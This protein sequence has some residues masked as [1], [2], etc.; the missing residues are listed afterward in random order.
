[1]DKGQIREVVSDPG[2]IRGIYNYCDRWCERCT[3]SARC[4]V[5]AAEQASPSID[6]D[7]AAFWRQ[8]H[9][10]LGVAMELLKEAAD[11]YG[12]DFDP[13]M[14]EEDEALEQAGIAGSGADQI[15]NAVRLH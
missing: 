14:S 13:L 11:E 6:M 2:L 12:L 7:N 15:N 5:F 1:M 8:L 10:T 9:D 3:L 4:A